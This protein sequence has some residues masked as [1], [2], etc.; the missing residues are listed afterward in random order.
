[1]KISW[2][3]HVGIGCLLFA[4]SPE[5]FSQTAPCGST[6]AEFR[7]VAAKS[8]G[9]FQGTG[10]SCAG[11]GTHGLQYQ[12]V[13]YIRRLYA[14]ALSVDTTSWRLNAVDFFK[15][16]STIGLLSFE[17]GRT[18]T[19]PAP[20]DIIVFGA[21]ARNP[22]GHVAIVSQISGNVVTCIEQNWSKSG[23]ANLTVSFQNGS[24]IIQ[25]RGTY[26]ILGWLRRAPIQ[27]V[28]QP[29]PGQGKDIWTTS[30][31]SYA[32]GG[33]FP[34]GG[35]DNFELVVGGW[36][37]S[38]YSLLQFD[39]TGLPNN[40]S[41]ARLEMFAIP[42][43]GTGATGV[44][45]DRIS[46][47]WDWRAQGTGRDRLRLWWADRPNAVQWIPQAQPAPVAGQW[48][49]IDV[50]SLYNAWKSG[51]YPNFGIQLRPVMNFNTW[52]EFY[53]SDYLGDPALRPKL[54]VDP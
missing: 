43:R 24:Y 36:G 1:M 52:A 37:D 50:T 38:Y 14:E 17:N 22:Y 30:V 9:E 20:D 15:N 4:F 32:P 23:T 2:L 41:S 47:F 54:V 48:Y 35:Q 46:E 34:G 29:G 51:T 44:F 53:S 27:N 3:P 25:D 12:C 42:S 5:T 18:A 8:N 28:V 10:D 13:E 6:L 31:Y 19:P 11:R 16:S 26:H 40:A 49:R 33:S 45:V 39:L 21:T 7:D